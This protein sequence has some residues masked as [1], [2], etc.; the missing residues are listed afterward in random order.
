MLKTERLLSRPWELP[1][2]T[3]INRLPAR[4]TLIPYRTTAQAFSCVREKSPWFKS[5]N[6][7]WKFRLVGNPEAVPAGFFK[8]AASETGYR[9]IEVPGNWNMQGYD[10]PHYTN[11]QMP[12]ENNPPYVPDDNPTG[13][14]RKAFTVPA[15]WK[16]RR[17]VIHFGG[18]ESMFYL[19]VNGQQ[20][21]MAKD[22]RLPA[23][24]DITSYVKTGSNML[25]V[26]VIRYSDGSYVEDQDHW[27][28]AGIHRDVYLYSTDK[29]YLED[30][31]ATATLD[32]NFSDGRLNI[33]AK[34]GFADEP[35]SGFTVEALLYDGKKQVA[36]LSKGV[37]AWYR[38]DYGSC[39]M[40]TILRKPR[41]W[42]A[43]QPNLYTLVIVLRSEKGRIL[44]T[45]SCRIGFRTVEVKNRELLINGKAVLIKGVNRH[46]HHDARGKAVPRETMIR[47]IEVLKQ[48]NFNAVRTCHY[49]ND[50]VWYDLCDEYGI[51][52]LDEANIESHANYHTLC[53]NPRWSQAFYERVMNMVLRDKN[54]PCVIGWSLGNESGYGENHDRAADAVRAYDPSRFLH[55]EGALKRSWRQGSNVYDEHGWRANDIIDPMYPS[56]SVLEENAR[57]ASKNEYRPFIM[58]EYTH[59]MG[60]SNG[61][62]KEYWD[63]IKKHHGL[64]GGF[65]WD[66]VDQGILAKSE[67]GNRKS[68][69]RIAD[70]DGMGKRALEAARAECHK[71]GGRFFWGYGGDFGDK[72]NDANFC[73][74]GM[75]WPDRTPHPGM[76]EFKKLVQP[77]AMQLK[78]SSLAVTNE[79]YFTGMDWLQGRW[80]VK[81]N[82]RI[83][84]KGKLKILKTAPGQTAS[85]KLPLRKLTLKPGEESFLMVSF[86][87]RSRTSWCPKGHEV[88][89][90]QFVLGKA[91]PV[92]L[93][94]LG[95]ATFSESSNS[96]RI[97]AGR[98]H[99]VFSRTTGMITS[100]KHDGTELV[101]KGPKL[102]VWRAATDNDGIKRWSGQKRKPLGKWLTAGLNK[103]SFGKAVTSVRRR[104]GCVE[105]SVRRPAFAIGP[106]PAFEHTH[107][108]TITGNGRIHVSNKVVA[109]KDL[110]ELPRIGVTM[111]LVPGLESLKWYGCGPHES[112]CDRKAG[113]AVD[114][115]GGTVSGQ[116]VPYIL[117]Q[118]HGNKVDVRWMSLAGLNKKVTFRAKTLMECSA[119][120]FTADDLFA[121]FHTN[122]LSPRKEVIVNIDC[123]QRGLGTGSCGP[124]TLEKYQVPPGKY[125]FGY[126]IEV[127]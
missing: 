89:W 17:I 67:I 6:G 21:G 10:K 77:V 29:A 117:P 18:V 103:I 37:S 49:P 51:Y 126:S 96:I 36:A 53:R 15:A 123:R 60:N 85:L 113:A 69:L 12:F 75:V 28:M 120:H 7:T 92:L 56:I 114:V 22:C 46:D 80:E 57:N 8:P 41:Q 112:Y 108:Y 98:V 45:T 94:R 54:H 118:E 121:A 104:G 90:E 44:E 4:A 119:S 107:V 99:V 13:L 48:F 70:H 20:V 66:W 11:V 124:Q 64:Q 111:Q 39:E 71:P 110:P 32:D 2:L 30:V 97:V 65:I 74:N 55:H 88:A 84:Q 35:E 81:V 91:S 14:F 23:E 3:H 27:W 43:E 109:G 101:V 82:G 62:L 115:Y 1:E 100:L 58:C 93:K 122:E 125:E 68:E 25:A 59:A 78:G 31:F 105:V 19:Y 83:V 127:D 9:P 50:P 87:A 5:L 42:S 86:A 47:D 79:Q 72:P 102:N 116:Y 24:F 52:I 26:M 73:I 95:G 61:N 34:L 63:L 38:V 16:G 40:G 106:E 33:K 76:F